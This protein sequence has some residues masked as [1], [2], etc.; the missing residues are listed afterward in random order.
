[1]TD[2]DWLSELDG[3][4]TRILIQWPDADSII[5]P[6]QRDIRFVL[7][8]PHEVTD[9]EVMLRD[10][11]GRSTAAAVNYL[12]FEDELGPTLAKMSQL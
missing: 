6:I 1:M 7:T 8:R 2:E 12:D 9:W 11:K 3:K 4:F 5:R 10:I